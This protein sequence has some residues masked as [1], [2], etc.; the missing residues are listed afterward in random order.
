MVKRRHAGSAVIKRVPQSKYRASDR[1]KNTRS[2]RDAAKGASGQAKATCYPILLYKKRRQKSMTQG[3]A[4]STAITRISV[5]LKRSGSRQQYSFSVVR[6]RKTRSVMHT[7]KSGI[8]R[9][10]QTKATGR[11]ADLSVAFISRLLFR[12]SLP[13]VSPRR[14]T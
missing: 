5:K 4:G 7:Q 11:S 1:K 10:I 3:P 8:P 9:M 13:A 12:I 6:E 2:A 14:L